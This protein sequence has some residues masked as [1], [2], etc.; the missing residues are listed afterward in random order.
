MTT[1]TTTWVNSQVTTTTG[2]RGVETGNDNR[3]LKHNTV[4]VTPVCRMRDKKFTQ[5]SNTDSTVQTEVYRLLKK[6]S[7]ASGF[8]AA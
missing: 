4:Q 2:K 3:P 7:Q 6:T 5:R 8:R 1:M